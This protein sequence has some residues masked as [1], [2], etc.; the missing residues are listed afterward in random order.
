MNLDHRNVLIDASISIPFFHVHIIQET[1]IKLKM[2]FLIEQFAVSRA[3]KPV[4]IFYA[5][6]KPRSTD[7]KVLRLW[8]VRSGYAGLQHWLE[9]PRGCFWPAF[10]S[11]E[12]S[13]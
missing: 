12:K 2:K 13:S 11:T 9:M 7:L 1:K 8:N 4:D 3:S 6:K 5:V 10:R